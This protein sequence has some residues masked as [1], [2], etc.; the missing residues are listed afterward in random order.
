[1][2]STIDLHPGKRELALCAPMG[3]D[4]GGLI[5]IE[6]F[7]KGPRLKFRAQSSRVKT[8]NPKL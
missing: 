2:V 3:P 6:R 8:L 7:G 4:Y 5:R 1:M